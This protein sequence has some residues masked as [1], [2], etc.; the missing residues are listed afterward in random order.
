L[1]GVD[2]N[3]ENRLA[4][5]ADHVE[6]ELNPA[7]ANDVQKRHPAKSAAAVVEESVESRY[8]LPLSPKAWDDLKGTDLTAYMLSTMAL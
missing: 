1:A 3:P 7:L 8:P 4:S 6:A 2:E 5:L